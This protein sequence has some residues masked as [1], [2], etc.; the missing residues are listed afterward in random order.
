MIV[1]ILRALY[2]VY[3]LTEATTKRLLLRAEDVILEV[4]N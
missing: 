1:G 2:N 3:K 4:N